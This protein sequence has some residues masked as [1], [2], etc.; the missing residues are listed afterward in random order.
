M[1]GNNYQVDKEPLQGIPLPIVEVD[2]QQ[3]IITLVDQIITDKKQN[4][5]ADTSAL[6]SNIDKIVYQLY[7][8][9]EEEI[10][11]V[12]QSKTL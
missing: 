8:L 3:T 9:T 4:P 11:I 1:Q 5:Q 12:E 6:E 7:G 2:Q 10:K